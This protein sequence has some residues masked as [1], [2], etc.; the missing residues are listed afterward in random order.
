MNGKGSK[1]RN[2]F[3]AEWHDNYS[4]IK[5]KKLSAE[6][7]STKVSNVSKKEKKSK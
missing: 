3:S 4:K 2:C 6:K 7:Q 5:W 1:P